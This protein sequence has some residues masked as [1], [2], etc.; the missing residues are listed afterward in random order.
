[1]NPCAGCGRKGNCPNK[2]KPKADFIRHMKRLNRKM[3]KN[4]NAHKLAKFV[5]EG[6]SY[7]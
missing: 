6:G 4:A 2:C 3:R 5:Q 7:A 1:M